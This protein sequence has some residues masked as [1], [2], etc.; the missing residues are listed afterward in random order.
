MNCAYRSHKGPGQVPPK[1]PPLPGGTTCAAC[2]NP[3]EPNEREHRGFK[4]PE[5]DFA[6]RDIQPDYMTP[7]E[8]IA[9]IGRLAV[10]AAAAVTIM[11]IGMGFIY[12]RWV[13]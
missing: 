7:W 12:G 8:W 13:L 10:A 6:G 5:P 11:G 3:F 9:D 1:C 4:D 2:A